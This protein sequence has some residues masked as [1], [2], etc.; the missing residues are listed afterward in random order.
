MIL[1]LLFGVSML[2]HENRHKK[3]SASL[4]EMSRL[5]HRLAASEEANKIP[6]D[7]EID[8]RDLL[9]EFKKLKER[10]VFLESQLI[11]SKNVRLA[12]AEYR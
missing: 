5:R 1:I 12:K 10:V 4:R 11:E 3:A 6:R 7:N 9:I 8:M 2:G